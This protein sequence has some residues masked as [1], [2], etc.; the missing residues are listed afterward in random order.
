M[1]NKDHVV[2]EK[3]SITEKQEHQTVPEGVR[4]SR[5][6]EAKQEANRRNSQRSTGP[7]TPRGKKNS[8][9]NALKHGLLSNKALYDENGRL[10]DEGLYAFQ[11]D[12]FEQYGSDDVRTQVLVDLAVADYSRN[13]R[14]FEIERKTTWLDSLALIHR[15]SVGN[16]K[17]LIDD[18]KALADLR[19]ERMAQQ[20]QEAGDEENEPPL[21]PEVRLPNDATEP[22]MSDNP[23]S[24]EVAAST[25]AAA[26]SSASEIPSPLGT[27]AVRVPSEILQDPLEGT[28]ASV[29]DGVI[30]E[31]EASDSEALQDGDPALST[32][33][34]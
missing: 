25:P 4:S 31:P 30:A 28:P 6:S 10:K 2:V 3:A 7:I 21:E 34:Q 16:R 5:T 26:D 12:L 13:M 1:Q 32:T 19:A 33:I 22:P 18:L 9:L 27:G 29:H 23:S 15:Y 17:A 24:K 14:A 20:D 11:R 8:S